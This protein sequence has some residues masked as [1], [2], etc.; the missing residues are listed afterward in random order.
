MARAR[1]GVRDIIQGIAGGRRRRLEARQPVDEPVVLLVVVDSGSVR[2]GEGQGEVRATG[3]GGWGSTVAIALEKREG[4]TV[5]VVTVDSAD[6]AV[7]APARALAV[8]ADSS[9]VRASLDSTLDYISVRVD[10]SSVKARARL[11]PGGGV[12]VKADSSTVAVEAEPSAPGEYWADVEADSSGIRV[13]F[14]GKA[15]YVVEER[16]VETSSIRIAR[17]GGDAG[18][19]VK[20]RV[21]ADSSSVRLE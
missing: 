16:R 5:A 18:A 12:Y 2:V 1:R 3:W 10:A 7:A 15:R 17:P 19:T 13:S 8:V 11:A 14:N 20:A 21:R 6:V 4:K 9:S